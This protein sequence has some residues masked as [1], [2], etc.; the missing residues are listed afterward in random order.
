MFSQTQ[1]NGELRLPYCNHSYNSCW[2]Q[3]GLFRRRVFTTA[4]KTTCEFSSKQG[5][6]EIRMSIAIFGTLGTPGIIPVKY[7]KES[8]IG[9]LLFLPLHLYGLIWLF[10]S[11]LIITCT[12]HIRKYFQFSFLQ[13]YIFLTSLATADLLCG[14]LSIPIKAKVEKRS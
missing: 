9:Y 11:F 6:L 3:F 7:F 2:E 10:S 14:V 5:N 4:S 8:G 1:E 12:T 13:M